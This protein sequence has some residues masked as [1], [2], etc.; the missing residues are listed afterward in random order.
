MT[1]PLT[2]FFDHR[3]PGA[4]CQRIRDDGHLADRQYDR[5]LLDGE[6]TPKDRERSGLEHLFGF[7][8]FHFR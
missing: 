7:K 5:N 4:Y 8:L 2:G 1:M 6:G 3:W